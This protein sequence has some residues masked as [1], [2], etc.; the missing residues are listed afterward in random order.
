[1]DTLDDIGKKK[2]L[3]VRE[4]F[5]CTNNMV[6]ESIAV[7]GSS[8]TETLYDVVVRIRFLCMRYRCQVRFICFTGTQMVVQGTNVLFRGSLYKRVMN[9][10]PMLLFISLGGSVLKSS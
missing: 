3:D 2:W 9:V 8:R 4:V 1:M 7:T 5:V 6:P 10:K